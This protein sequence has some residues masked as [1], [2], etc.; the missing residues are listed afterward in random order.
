MIEIRGVQTTN[1][2]RTDLFIESTQNL[3]IDARHLMLFP[4][5]IDPHVHIR[6]PGEEHKESWDT[7][8]KAALAGGVTT[9]FD[10]PNNSPP[11]VTLQAL[12]AKKKS[13]DAILHAH[14]LPLRYGLYLGAD[15]TH[16]NEIKRSAPNAIGLK[17]YMGGSTGSLLMH[18]DQAL[19][20]A[21]R[22]A[23]E[24][25]LLVAVHAEDEQLIQT[26]RHAFREQQ[27]PSLHSQ[28]RNPLVAARA[29]E[30]ALTLAAKYRT[31]LYIAH[32]ST[33]CEL[34]LIEAA[35]KQGLSVFA[36]ATPHH[37]FFSDTL[38]QTL[39]TCALVNPPLRTQQDVEALW[40]A[41]HHET[42]DVIGTDHAPHLLHEKQQPYGLAPCGFP[43]LGLTLPLLLT[44][45]HAGKISL[46]EIVSLTHT[47]V[48]EIFRLP[49]NEDVVLVDLSMQRT[50]HPRHLH[51]KAG[52]S[53]YA[54]MVL[55]GWPRYVI[56]QGQ[57]FDLAHGFHTP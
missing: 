20:E 25:D 55:Q 30:R 39:G 53:P 22:L 45:Y 10:M 44:A 19:D 48:Q 52:W 57:C 28:I 5:L 8:A 38:Y 37:L 41:I 13:I 15:E 29:I 1:G 2:K 42:I 54:G 46:E 21:F 14:Q 27:D 50:V 40:D 24:A 11:C 35:K 56:A 18:Q 16:L 17:I 4:A 33:Q 49:L 36:E 7:G 31:R 9:I 12:Q 32:V 23:S 43:S 26:Q 6:T 34:S 51:S 47:R 3:L